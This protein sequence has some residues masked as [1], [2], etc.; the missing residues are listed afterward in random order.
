MRDMLHVLAGVH[1]RHTV[2]IDALAHVLPDEMAAASAV[3]VDTWR[4]GNALFAPRQQRY[5][6]AL[7][8]SGIVRAVCHVSLELLGP[9]AKR[10]V[11][12]AA[13]DGAGVGAHVSPSLNGFNFNSARTTRA[14][15]NSNAS[16]SS[17]LGASATQRRRRRLSSMVRRPLP[18]HS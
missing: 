3:R 15:R 7:V 17:N 16:P 2:V 14:H 18:M 5:S 1:S 11:G 12:A 10:A 9:N 6:T 13:G 8:H 4:G